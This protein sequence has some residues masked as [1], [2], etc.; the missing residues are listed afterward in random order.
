MNLAFKLY[1]LCAVV[2]FFKMWAL[3]LVQGIGRLRAKAFVIAED[4]RLLGGEP[5]AQ[6]APIVQRASRAWRNDLE[7]IPIFLFLALIYVIAGC[8]PRGAAIY[9]PLF[10]LARISHSICYLEG[11]QPWRTLSYTVGVAICLALCLHI[12]IAVFAAPP[13]LALGAAARMVN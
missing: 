6:E 13:H 9:F 1:A 5:A 3:S 7:N 2:L 11:L 8:W 4:A 12:L 10:T